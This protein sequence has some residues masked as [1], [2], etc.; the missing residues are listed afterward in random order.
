MYED[1]MYKYK[2]KD[3][4]TG[5]L[6]SASCQ[7][8]GGTYCRQN[9]VAEASDNFG[10]WDEWE[11]AGRGKDRVEMLR[12]VSNTRPQKMAHQHHQCGL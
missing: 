7:S 11:E 10:G 4:Y 2:Y 9:A 3:R 12:H 5:I 1:G 8:G 6:P